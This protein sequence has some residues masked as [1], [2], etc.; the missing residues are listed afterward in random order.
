MKMQLLRRR[1]PVHPIPVFVFERFADRSNLG[2]S[3]NADVQKSKPIIKP[4][5]KRRNSMRGDF[6]L[7]AVAHLQ[8]EKDLKENKKK[9]NEKKSNEKKLQA[10]R[11][12]VRKSNQSSKD[13][14]PISSKGEI[15]RRIKVR[16]SNPSSNDYRPMRSTGSTSPN[17]DDGTL[18]SLLQIRSMSATTTSTLKKSLVYSSSSQSLSR[19]LKSKKTLEELLRGHVK[20]TNHLKVLSSMSAALVKEPL[21]LKRKKMNWLD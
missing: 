17:Q 3:V 18:S 11:T 21:Q 14:R 9:S 10:V 2:Q 19:N 4:F 20:S 15:S 6:Y 1:A 12:K 8:L 13:T 16:K 5:R 7:E